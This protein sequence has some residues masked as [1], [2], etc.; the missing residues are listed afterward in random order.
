MNSSDFGRCLF[1]AGAIG[2]LVAGCGGSQFPI[3]TPSEIPQSRA[4]SGYRLLYSFGAGTDGQMPKAGLIV[5]HRELY[6]TTYGGGANG[7]GTVFKISRTGTE[8][9]LYNFRAANDGTNPSAALTAMNGHLYGTTEYGGNPGNDGTVF[10]LATNGTE[11]VLHSF[12]GYPTRGGA[13]PVASLI[14]VNGTLYGTTENGGGSPCNGKGCGIVFSMNPAGDEKVLHGF[15]GYGGLDGANP[16]A[17]LIYAHGSF[18]GTTQHG[19]GEVVKDRGN[20]G[21]IFRINM[22]HR[23]KVVYIF[24]YYPYSSNGCFPQGGLADVK[25]TLYGTTSGNG[26]YGGGSV[27][28]YHHPKRP[29]LLHGFGYGSDGS[30]PAATL[31][32]VKG[33]LYGTTAKGGMYGGGTV[34]SINPT[35]GTE[36]VLHS[37]GNGSDGATPL[38]GLID[39]KGTLYGTT[40]AGGTNGNGT[41]FALTP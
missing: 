8:K 12:A 36:T 2:I 22:P 20:A 11:T 15:V 30:A 18:W 33:T 4:S 13:N 21:T 5:S 19:G 35:T 37:F 9:V 34:F 31:L 39:V 17:N 40:S 14:G 28:E 16:V 38:A 32:N 6:G 24:V 29:R 10:R 27:L 1:S 25:G 3:G 41:I 23:E 7:M 26:I